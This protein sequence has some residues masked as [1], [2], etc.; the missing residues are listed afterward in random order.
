MINIE[1]TVWN[2]GLHPWPETT[3]LVQD[4]PGAQDDG[5]L[6]GAIGS[7]QYAFLNFKVIV[8]PIICGKNEFV[9]K[10]KEKLG[11]KV[12]GE[13]IIIKLYVKDSS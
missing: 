10:F 13:K 5:L 1:K 8:P 7:K 9:F 12:F 6:V 3:C 11:G 2:W 4:L